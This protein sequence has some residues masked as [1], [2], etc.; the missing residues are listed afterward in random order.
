MFQV[1]ESFLT[2]KATVKSVKI[3]IIKLIKNIFFSIKANGANEN[4]I[5]IIAV[6]KIWKSTISLSEATF[7]TVQ[8][9]HK[10]YKK[11]FRYKIKPRKFLS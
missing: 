11:L 3:T 8:L 2:F 5:V 9:L 6:I 1:L 10:N 4:P 7:T